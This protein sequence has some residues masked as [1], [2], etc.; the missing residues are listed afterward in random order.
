MDRN[1]QHAEHNKKR[2]DSN[3][4][5]KTN[6][7][8]ARL[9]E[10]GID[11]IFRI[12]SWAERRLNHYI[13]EKQRRKLYRIIF[14]SESREGKRF[15]MLLTYLIIGSVLTVM[16]ET[17][18][19]FHKAYWW[20]FFILEWLFT[21]LFT[22]EYVLRLYCAR[23]P[24]RYATSF[25]G[26]VDLLAILPT[27]LSF[28]LLGAQHLLIVRVL[29]LLRIFRIFKMGHFVREGA[30]VVEAL[31]ASRRKIYVFLAFV[32]LIAI[33]IGSF[34]YM[35]EG[36]HNPQIT[37]IP[38]GIYWAI[39]TL[40]T[41]GYGDIVPVTPLGKMLASMVMIL[42]YGIIA[43]P[44]GIVTA[45]ISGRVMNLKEVEF[46]ECRYCGQQEHHTHAV[47]CHRCG[48]KLRAHEL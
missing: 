43:V 31:R 2:N 1:K 24:V 32:L 47:F 22:V 7:F 41:V 48:K 29:R 23:N 33:L 9:R 20:I 3:F 18:T 27:Y 26:L 37:S 5:T 39:V 44:T 40:T 38:N 25:F 28:F 30:I 14:L 13:N 42:G 17:V 6:A 16:M 34:M 12:G 36:R 15:D 19:D 8:L 4:F 35:V 21:L 11:I 10:V 46:I 45:E